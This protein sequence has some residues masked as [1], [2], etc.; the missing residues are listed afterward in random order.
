MPKAG[1]SDRVVYLNGAF[2]DERLACVPVTDRGLN[3]GDG[4]FETMKATE[5]HIAFLEDHFRRLR[6][7]ARFLGIPIKPLRA[8]LE[9]GPRSRLLSEL[10]ERNGLMDR[11]A[12]VRV[13]V[14]R[15]VGAVGFAPPRTRG[16]EPTV[17]VTASPLDARR[18]SSM[19][20]RG[21]RAALV[22]TCLPQVPG[23]KTLN[24][25]PNVLGAIEAGRRRADEGIFVDGNGMLTEGTS[26]NVFVVAGG[27]VTTPPL[28]PPASCREG[29]VLPGVTRKAVIALAREAGIM[30]REAP[31]SVRDAQRCDEAFLTNSIIGVAPLVSIDN[32]PVGSGRPGAVTREVQKAYEAAARRRGSP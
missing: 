14:T 9:K 24:C 6:E 26:S 23:F 25:L 8:L 12:R 1:L 2:V 7:G 3:Y 17:I 30:V 16:L 18:I 22:T 28:A 21:L 4:L 27:A 20:R 13:T 10:L 29:G 5:G 31:V 32:V 15:G 11:E 19:Q